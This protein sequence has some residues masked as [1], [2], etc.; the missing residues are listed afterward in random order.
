MISVCTNDFVE[1]KKN[2]KDFRLIW[3]TSF[4]M[5]IDCDHSQKKNRN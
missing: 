5:H 3:S 4:S 1:T 2:V